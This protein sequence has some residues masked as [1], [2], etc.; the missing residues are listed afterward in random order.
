MINFRP[1]TEITL[2]GHTFTITHWSP[3]KVMKNIPKIGR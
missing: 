1:T 3:T 2:S